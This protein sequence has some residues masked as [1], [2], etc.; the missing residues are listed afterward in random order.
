MA[1]FLSYSGWLGWFVG[2]NDGGVFGWPE[3]L[4]GQG[5]WV[6]VGGW[7]TLAFFFFFPS[8]ICGFEL[9]VEC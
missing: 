1:R 2:H 3:W 6:M 7:P 4:M 5:L 9:L 8:P